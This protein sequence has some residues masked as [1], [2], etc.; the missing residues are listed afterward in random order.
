MRRSEIKNVRE[1][2][3]A[4]VNDRFVVFVIAI[5]SFRAIIV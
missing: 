3:P 1:V 5:A 2:N 4:G